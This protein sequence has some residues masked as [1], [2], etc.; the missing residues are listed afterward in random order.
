MPH[1]NLT[2]RES[3]LVYFCVIPILLPPSPCTCTLVVVVVVVVVVDKLL[4]KKSTTV[5]VL[6]V[7]DP[8]TREKNLDSSRLGRE[9]TAFLFQERAKGYLFVFFLVLSRE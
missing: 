3:E 6:S 9:Q 2:K 7:A 8:S 4:T 5:L 1:G